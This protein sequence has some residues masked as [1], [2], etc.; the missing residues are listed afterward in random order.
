MKLSKRELE[1][2]L[3]NLTNEGMLDQMLTD[4][5]IFDYAHRVWQN[6]HLVWVKFIR[7]V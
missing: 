6:K 5:V 2:A 4:K 1:N 3:D 7:S